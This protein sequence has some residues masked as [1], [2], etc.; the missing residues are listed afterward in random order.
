MCHFVSQWGLVCDTLIL[1]W[2]PARSPASTRQMFGTDFQYQRRPST[3]AGYLPFSSRPSHTLPRFVFHNNL[4]SAP[5]FSILFVSSFINYMKYFL[6]L[7]TAL[8]SVLFLNNTL[9]YSNMRHSYRMETERLIWLEM[10]LVLER[11][12]PLLA[13]YMRIIFLAGKDHSGNFKS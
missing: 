1:S 8:I 4:S 10:E 3:E 11:E 12:E 6:M 5:T 2:R 7:L 9:Q 13:S